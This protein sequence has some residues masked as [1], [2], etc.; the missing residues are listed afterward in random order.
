MKK[1]Y[2]GNLPWTATEE[3][4]KA[5]FASAGT[6]GSA[7]IILD[8]ETNRSRG[9]GFVEVEDVESMISAMDG[10]DFIGRPLK[11]SEA[12][13]RSPQESRPSYR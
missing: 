9:F 10:K 7:R 1:L 3:G 13:E 8:R 2:V 6:V 11:V 4:L 12:R 5:H